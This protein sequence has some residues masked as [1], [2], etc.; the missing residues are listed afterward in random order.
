MADDVWLQLARDMAGASAAIDASNPWRKGS[1]AIG[2]LSQ[3]AYPA[4]AS[5]PKE[6]LIGIALSQFLSGALGG[7]ADTYTQ[8]RIPEYQSV[9]EAATAGRELPTTEYL[10]S[11]SALFREAKQKGQL[12]QAM[13][14]SDQLQNE[15]ALEADLQ[16]AKQNASIDIEKEIVK[17]FLDDPKKARKTF[18]ILAGEDAGTEQSSV[19]DAVEGLPESS[20]KAAIEELGNAGTLDTNLNFIADQFE[21]AKNINSVKALVP[22]S[23]SANE[24]AGIS[25]AIVGAM[26]KVR[27]NELS[28]TARKEYLKLMPDWNDTKEQIDAKKDRVIELTKS[29]VKPTPVLERA[30][31]RATTPTAPTGAPPPNMTFEQFKAWKYGR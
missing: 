11:D 10:D 20:R 15:R 5:D 2:N 19:L 29:M 16:K 14:L 26:E 22:G 7:V 13:R 4:R 9:M 28:E 17:K 31:I 21:K 30:G 8:N 12:F 23:T 24:M 18:S 6:A 25:T 1:V 3:Q 27:A